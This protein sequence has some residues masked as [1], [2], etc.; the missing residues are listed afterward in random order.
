[1]TRFLLGCMAFLCLLAPIKL[2]AQ[3]QPELPFPTGGFGLAA[4][5]ERGTLN[6]LDLTGTSFQMRVLKAWSTFPAFFLGVDSKI[7]SLSLD[8]QTGD[9][10]GTG[11]AAGPTLGAMIP[12]SLF[13]DLEALGVHKSAGAPVYG[14]FNVVDVMHFDGGNRIGGQSLSLG[15]QIPLPLPTTS[16]LIALQGEYST[17]F[18]GKE[19]L[20]PGD[21]RQSI[22]RE[23]WFFMLQIGVPFF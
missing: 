2:L 22:D 18:Y 4:G 8:T 21:S 20:F 16:V 9:L 15:F 17:Y 1:M 14:R 11:F 3:N 10:N 7:S 19:R 12:F 6:G 13:M 5:F 23:G